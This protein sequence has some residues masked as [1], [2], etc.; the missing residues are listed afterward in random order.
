[1]RLYCCQEPQILRL[2][3]ELLHLVVYEHLLPSFYARMGNQLRFFGF[4]SFFSTCK[5]FSNL[6]F[7]WNPCRMIILPCQ[8][9]IKQLRVRHCVAFNV[10][11]PTYYAHVPG[12]GWQ[13]LGVDPHGQIWHSMYNLVRR[14][15]FINYIF[16]PSQTRDTSILGTTG[17]GGRGAEERLSERAARPREASDRSRCWPCAM[18]ADPWAF[19]ATAGCCGSTF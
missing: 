9:W 15:G 8:V 7:T 5:H 12:H 3:T 6:K 2:P 14:H 10:P 1:M 18:S 11:T 4:Q 16:P 19:G 17:C 13:L